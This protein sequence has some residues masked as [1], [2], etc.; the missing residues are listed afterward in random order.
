[1]QSLV[2]L[3][4]NAGIFRNFISISA[5]LPLLD[6]QQEAGKKSLLYHKSTSS[7]SVS[8]RNYVSTLI[9]YIKSYEGG[10]IRIYYW[11]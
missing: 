4:K 8:I 10:K 6:T 1:M 9:T 7:S 3:S 2:R 11:P 5:I